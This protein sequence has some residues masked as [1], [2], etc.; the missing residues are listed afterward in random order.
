MGKLCLNSSFILSLM[1]MGGFFCKE[2]LSNNR[3][4]LYW[5]TGILY[6][7]WWFQVE[8]RP[9]YL[10]GA[11]KQCECH[12]PLDH[13]AQCAAH[14]SHPALPC[15]GISYPPA[16]GDN[17]HCHTLPS[18]PCVLVKAA[19]LPGD[20]WWDYR[21]SSC[22]PRT[23]DSG[24]WAWRYVRVLWF[25]ICCLLLE[26]NSLLALHFFQCINW[27][28]NNNNNNIKNYFSLKTFQ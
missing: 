6:C 24:H 27:H 4:S 13:S 19:A 11:N 1:I 10:C 2:D 3:S 23:C 16:P 14:T 8:Q 5:V 12:Q 7:A 26:N 18:M 22:H 20:P 21:G 17:Q 28:N 9:N 25:C 15:P